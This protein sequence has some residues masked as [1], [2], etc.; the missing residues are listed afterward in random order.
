MKTATAISLILVIGATSRAEATSFALI[1]S[2]PTLLNMA[3]LILGIAGIVIGLQL[4]KVIRGGFLCRA[5]QVLVA[6]FGV[7]VLGQVSILVQTL[8]IASLPVWVTP[9]LTVIWAGIFFYGVF[10][11]KRVLS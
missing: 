10:E 1:A 2:P 6:G 5:W 11:T 3:V 7:L 9:A 8:E 4:L